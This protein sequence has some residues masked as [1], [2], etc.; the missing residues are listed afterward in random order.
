LCKKPISWSISKEKKVLV[1][2][3]ES[4]KKKHIP[5]VGKYSPER[6][7]DTK[8]LTIGARGKMGYYK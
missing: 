2:E 6:S 7:L 4:K 3:D 5:G 8:F 1:F